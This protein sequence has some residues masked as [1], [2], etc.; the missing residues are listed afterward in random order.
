MLEVRQPLRHVRED[1][2]PDVPNSQQRML[3]G[4][5]GYLP[6]GDTLIYEGDSDGL[7]RTV[8]CKGCLGIKDSTPN[9]PA[10][11]APLGTRVLSGR[12][13]EPGYRE[14][15]RIARTWGYD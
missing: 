12:V 1:Q 5:V 4:L 9:E 7:W 15:C 13:G 6:E 8:T 14:F 3:C 2:G 10:P 11:I